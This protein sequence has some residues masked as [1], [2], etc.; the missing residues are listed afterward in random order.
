MTA[1]VFQ[2]LVGQDAVVEELT[3]AAE[4]AAT[5]GGGM[6]HAWL[7]TGPPGSGRSVA[8]RAFAAALQCPRRGCGDC[9]TCHTTLSGSHGDVTHVVPDGLTIGVATMRDLIAAASRSPSTGNRQI[10]LVEDA[11][12]LTEAAGN[13]LLKSIEEPP[14]RTVFLLCAPSANPAEIS[15]TIRSRCRLVALVQPSVDAVAELLTRTDNADPATAALY[16]AAAQGHIG[17]ARRLV[18][19]VEARQRRESILAI[20]RQLSSVSACF[21][22]ADQL[23]AA[24]ESEAAAANDGIAER[25]R[26]ELEMALGKGGTGKGATKATRGSAGVIKDLERRQKMRLTRAQRDTLD[27]ALIDLAAFYRDV[28]LIGL[29]STVSPIHPDVGDIARSA[30]QKWT[31]E[32]VLRRIDAI[33]HCRESIDANVRPRIAVESMMLKLWKG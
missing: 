27:R 18:T 3:A 25:E 21:V 20:P 32:S 4:A 26:A 16:A 2:A 5:G 17:R 19:D 15:V 28:L 1:P 29:G 31:A 13:A 22:A 6:T 30:S 11:D 14:A 9:A 23:I 33:L 8:A 24:A 7:F 12:R 10:L